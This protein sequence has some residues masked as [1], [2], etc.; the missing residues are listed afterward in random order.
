MVVGFRY[1]FGT[2]KCEC[3][4]IDI[5]GHLLQVIDW[6]KASCY[7][8]ILLTSTHHSRA[9]SDLHLEMHVTH[10]FVLDRFV[11]LFISN[12]SSVSFRSNE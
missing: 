5:G 10:A 3:I 6:G 1:E 11:L 12:A 7:I 8:I 4:C 2:F 9:K